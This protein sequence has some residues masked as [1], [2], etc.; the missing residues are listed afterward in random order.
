MPANLKAL[1]IFGL[2]NPGVILAG[3]AMG[4]AADQP[5]KI[6]VGAFA[7][8]FAGL[9]VAWLAGALGLPTGFGGGVAGMFALY[10]ALGALW[11]WIG[12]RYGK[13]V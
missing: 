4:R 7:A 13:K 11:S 9:L 8:A 1:L 6:L 12:W 2:L 3:L 5:Q 10:M